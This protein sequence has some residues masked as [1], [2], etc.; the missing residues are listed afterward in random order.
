M[1]QETLLKLGIPTYSVTIYTKLE[2]VTSQL[3]GDRMPEQ[4]GWIYG[5]STEVGDTHPDDATKQLISDNDIGSIW[6]C[7]KYGATE[8]IQDLRMT[9]L[10]FTSSQRPG[11]WFNPQRFF[12]VNIPMHTDLSTS[13]YKNPNK[14]SNVHVALTLYYIDKTAYK[15]LLAQGIILANGV[16]MKK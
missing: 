1:I 6:L 12:P 8:Y 16:T 15:N 13:K 5:L 2:D 7:L 10:V 4:I 9:N 11:M 3:I 14:I